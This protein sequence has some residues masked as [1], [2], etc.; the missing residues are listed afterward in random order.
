MQRQRSVLTF[1]KKEAII[2][3]VLSVSLLI[4]ATVI[5]VIERFENENLPS[6]GKHIFYISLKEKSAGGL[7]PINNASLN[8]NLKLQGYRKQDKTIRLDRFAYSNGEP[9]HLYYCECDLSFDS[10]TVSL[11]DTDGIVWLPTSYITHIADFRCYEVAIASNGAFDYP[12]SC[13]AE[14]SLSPRQFSD[15]FFVNYNS[16]VIIPFFGVDCYPNLNQSFKSVIYSEEMKHG[17]PVG[18]IPGENSFE[19][20]LFLKKKYEDYLKQLL[21]HKEST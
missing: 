16:D 11:V 4:P 21:F 17:T 9:S 3:G 7:K 15:I 18:T 1:H 10:F 8:V 14:P 6:Y 20:F 12:D 13:W 5:F 19:Q 2:L